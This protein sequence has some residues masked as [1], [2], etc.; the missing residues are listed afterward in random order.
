MKIRRRALLALAACLAC[1]G[2][3]AVTAAPELQYTGRVANAGTDGVTMLT[4]AQ[5]DGT[6]VHMAGSLLPELERLSGARLLITGQATN[7]A[8]PPAVDVERYEILDIN[9]QKPWVGLLVQDAGGYSI[10]DADV[11][12]T[13]LDRPPPA[14]LDQLGA[15]VWV[16]GTLAAEGVR[17]Q[18]FGV[19]RPPG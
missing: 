18:S 6:A 7:A 15:W 2:R 10:R 1:A 4:L 3:T 8:P 12:N 17:V 11:L 19:I 16:T 13:R 14:L 9:G 5:D